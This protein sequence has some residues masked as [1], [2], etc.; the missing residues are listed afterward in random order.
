MSAWTPKPKHTHHGAQPRR[1]SVQWQYYRQPNQKRHHEPDQW[2][3]HPVRPEDTVC[4][5]ADEQVILEW[6]AACQVQ[7]VWPKLWD[8]MNVLSRRG[9]S[10][11]QKVQVTRPERQKL[12]AVLQRL[13]TERKVVR[14]R[15]TN[16]ISLALPWQM[17]R[18]RD[19]VT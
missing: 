4:L 6:L 8:V 2:V 14:H 13:I 17:L 19:R 16:T 12:L 9:S 10:L 1:V 15:R 11:H 7:G 3:P 5:V 18:D